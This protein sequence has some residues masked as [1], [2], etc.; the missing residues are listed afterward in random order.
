[1]QPEVALADYPLRAGDATSR[2]LPRRLREVS[3]LAM[4][5]DGR[6]LAHHDEAAVVFEIDYAAGRIVK[7]F[8]LADLD[9]PVA[10]DF[11]GIAVAAGRI[12]LVT[13]SGRLYESGEGT[14]GESVLFIAYAT[15]AGR[16]CEIEGLAYDE[17]RGELLLMCKDARSEHLLGRLAI[18]R[19]SIAEKQLRDDAATV[20]AVRDLAGRIGA[21]RF[22]PSGIER[23]PVSG[24]Y[25][26]V[27]ARQGA[28]A[29]VTPDGEVVAVR[30]FAAPWHR[31]IEGIAFAPDGSLLV[32][33][34][35][36]EGRA[37]LTVYPAPG[38]RD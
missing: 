27:A 6:L 30:R 14:D 31:Q 7:R 26:V 4:T 9:A 37:M 1:M 15:G 24:N 16:N 23:H 29:E 36:G 10:G 2:E 25:F 33:D 19:W 32:A 13:S 35:G 20:I 34:E 5:D 22:R 11:E 8:Q 18:Y 21:N 28:V 12:Y 3:G 17:D 38:R